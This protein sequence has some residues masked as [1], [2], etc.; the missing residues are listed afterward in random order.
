MDHALVDAV[1]LPATG[2]ARR[3]PADTDVMRQLVAHL[4]RR[5]GRGR[6]GVTVE[7]TGIETAVAPVGE[8]D[9]VGD[10]VVMVGERVQRSRSEVPE[11]CCHPTLR[12]H[13]LAVDASEGGTVLEPGHGPVVR[14][15]DRP[16]N[17]G[18]GVGVAEQGQHAEGLL[19][20][21]GDVEPDPHG[22]WST[23]F[24][25]L[26]EVFAGHEP[27]ATCSSVGDQVRLAGSPPGFDG[28]LDLRGVVL[29]MLGERAQVAS[30]DPG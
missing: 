14:V 16:E 17:S 9:G 1:D 3:P 13:R 4:G 10:H 21:E 15:L 26:G 11:R 2:S 29:V 18:A 27:L 23:S 22:R 12:L 24:E 30:R 7:T 25:E 5:E 19:G 8:G 28:L 6:V 20:G